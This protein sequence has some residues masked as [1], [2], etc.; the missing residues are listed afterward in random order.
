[1]EPRPDLAIAVEAP[2]V[3]A[4]VDHARILAIGYRRPPFASGRLL[5]RLDARQ[6]IERVGLQSEPGSV[7]VVESLG[8]AASA[9]RELREAREEADR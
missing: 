2:G 8:E 7:L 1:V 3:L 6:T 4:G 9:R 5:L